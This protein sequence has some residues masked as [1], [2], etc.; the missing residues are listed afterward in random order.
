MPAVRLIRPLY[1]LLLLCGLSGAGLAADNWTVDGEHGELHVQGELQEGACRVEMDS[2]FQQVD[3]GTVSTDSLRAPGQHST[4]V[5]FRIYLRDCLRSHGAVRSLRTGNLTWSEN[6]PVVSVAFV[7]PADALTPALVH[8][9]SMTLSGVGLRLFSDN[10]EA[11]TLGRRGRP[12]FLDPG[13]DTLTFYVAPE[14][15]AALLAPGNY[16]ATVSFFLDY[17]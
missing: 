16:R 11:V 9:D 15:T 13:Q 10:L 8:P 12:Q 1:C 5:P 7:G 14:R 17:Q 2:A 3:L 6:Q 4:P